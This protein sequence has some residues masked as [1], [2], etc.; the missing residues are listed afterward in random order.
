MD[1]LIKASQINL[2]GHYDRKI[3][4][5]EKEWLKGRKRGHHRAVKRKKRNKQRKRERKR[6]KPNVN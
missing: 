4:K 3:L 5:G 6:E 2:F 1:G